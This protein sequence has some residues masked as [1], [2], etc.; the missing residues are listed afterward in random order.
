MPCACPQCV[1]AVAVMNVPS[2]ENPELK[3]SPCKAWSRSV[4]SSPW[5]TPKTGNLASRS[6]HIH[7]FQNLSRMFPVLAVAG[8]GSR[9]DPQ[10]EIGHPA[11]R[12][13]RLMQVPVLSASGI[14]IVSKACAILCEYWIFLRD[15]SFTI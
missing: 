11:H 2:V 1:A 7:F 10:D 15:V 8:A 13:R 3:G 12:H 14:E 9:L 6:I 4:Y 5:S